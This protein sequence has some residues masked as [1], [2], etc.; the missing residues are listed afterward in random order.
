MAIIF[1]SQIDNPAEATI[2]QHFAALLRKKG[3]PIFYLYALP[4]NDNE[5]ATIFSIHQQIAK[6]SAFQMQLYSTA[7]PLLNKMKSRF[8]TDILTQIVKSLPS[9]TILAPA[10]NDLF[11]INE[12]VTID[13]YNIIKDGTGIRLPGKLS[14]QPSKEFLRLSALDSDLPTITSSSLPKISTPQKKYAPK[15]PLSPLNW[16]LE[17]PAPGVMQYD[18]IVRFK[19]WIQPDG[20]TITKLLLFIGGQKVGLRTKIVRGDVMEQL[21]DFSIIAFNQHANVANLPCRLECSI[22]MECSDGSKETLTKFTIWKNE[23]IPEPQFALTKLHI[24][25]GTDNLGENA[26]IALTAEKSGK[27]IAEIWV[28]GQC[29]A[30]CPID[31][32]PQTIRW[33]NKIHGAPAH[34]WIREETT[35]TSFYGAILEKNNQ[36]RDTNRT[37]LPLK[38]S[39]VFFNRTMQIE[40]PQDTPTPT[41]CFINGKHVPSTSAIDQFKIT[42]LTLSQQSNALPAHL[43]CLDSDD[44][45]FTKLL[46][47]MINLRYQLFELA[48]L[49]NKHVDCLFDD[50]TQALVKPYKMVPDNGIW[51]FVF[52][53]TDGEELQHVP[54]TKI[55]EVSST[56]VTFN[57]T[58]TE[59]KDFLQYYRQNIRKIPDVFVD[60]QFSTNTIVLPYIAKS[61]KI[62]T[63]RIVLL[64]PAPAP[65]DELY[66]GCI[67]DNLSKNL[68]LEHIIID[69]QTETPGKHHIKSGDIVIVSRYITSG[70]LRELSDN[71]ENCAIYYIMDDDVMTAIDSKAIP[72]GY[73]RKIAEAA[74][75]DFQA[76][77]YLCD[78]FIVTAPSLAQRYNSDKT[79]YLAPPCLRWPHS[80]AHHD[81]Y[82]TIRIAYHGTDVHK[83]DV[84]FLIN[85]IKFLGKHYPQVEFE[86]FSGSAA[87]AEIRD[88]NYVLHKR[89]LNWTKYVKYSRDNPAHI[90]LAPMLNTPY[91]Q[92]K[93]IIKFHDTASLGAVG[94]YSAIQ[95]YNDFISN[96]IDGLL[97]PNDPSMWLQSIRYL[98]EDTS[99]LHKMAINCQT[100]AKKQ[101]NIAHVEQFWVEELQQWM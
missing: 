10:S 61:K 86:Y 20:R 47:S 38:K 44:H 67:L 1:V 37:A 101:G 4:H 9:C 54:L 72:H 85:T 11:L 13:S 6:N 55:R 22:I 36:C 83:D 28:L 79:L 84:S 70:W 49:N 45:V 21:D 7:D 98:L 90:A 12:K 99:I 59:Q 65:T 62:I 51:Y 42:Q 96:G 15:R 40:W 35:D 53:S 93:S 43:E 76:M 60:E 5:A 87:L 63:K 66:I 14:V 81:D 88:K 27:Y 97:V 75:S 2:L 16:K 33:M 50:G 48:I 57:P 30:S 92:G 89:P 100:T 8:N 74:L 58:G 69:T 32:T 73:R 78:K 3:Q 77:L 18:N 56:N 68:K 23:F 34:L 41:T 39:G 64:R 17:A 71:T 29:L 24:Q 52:R 94:I 80:M 26:K 91:N 31:A 82:S 25:T 95:P 19:G 46:W